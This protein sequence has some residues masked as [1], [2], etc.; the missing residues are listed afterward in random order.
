MNKQDLI[1]GEEFF[2][3]N[4]AFQIWIQG[5]DIREARVSFNG[6]YFYIWF[7]GKFIHSSKTFKSMAN[8]LEKLRAKWG[9]EAGEL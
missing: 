7:N 6:K 9:L 1:N 3:N 2:F 4:E 5:D 8:R